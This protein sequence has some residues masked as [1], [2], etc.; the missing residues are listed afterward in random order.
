MLKLIPD[1]RYIVIPFTKTAYFPSK[2]FT[3][4]G[5]FTTDQAA[6]LA[7]ARIEQGF[8]MLFVDNVY[9]SIYIWESNTWGQIGDNIKK[10]DLI[11][12]LQKFIHDNK[13]E[14]EL[15]DLL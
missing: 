13:P 12:L 3:I 2:M 11:N 10:T 7:E 4:P 14:W 1:I 8:C 9:S 15:N 6:Y 5:S